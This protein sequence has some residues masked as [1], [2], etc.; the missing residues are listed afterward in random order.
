M[1]RKLVFERQQDHVHHIVETTIDVIVQDADNSVSLRPNVG[2]PLFVICNLV[3]LGVSCTINLDYEASIT[4]E[5]VDGE[6]AYRMLA[7]KFVVQQTAAAKL[8]P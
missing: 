2:R 6:M 5:K 1:F 4:T 3:T 7:V 8:P